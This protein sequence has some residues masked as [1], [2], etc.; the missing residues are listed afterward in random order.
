[1]YIRPQ[2]PE[3]LHNDK[4]PSKYI[5]LNKW[6]GFTVTL[7]KYNNKYISARTK[8]DLFIRSTS[9]IFGHLKNL[10]QDPSNSFTTDNISSLLSPLKHEDVQSLTLDIFG[11]KISKITEAD[12]D[13][14]FKLLYITLVN[15]KVIP[16]NLFLRPS[17]EIEDK[18]VTSETLFNDFGP[19]RFDQASLTEKIDKFIN[20][21]SKNNIH[22]KFFGKILFYLDENNIVIGK[23]Y[24]IAPIHIL[25]LQSHELSNETK[26]KLLDALHKVYEN[27]LPAT[28]NNIK[29]Y[30]DLNQLIFTKFTDKILNFISDRPNPLQEISKNKPSMIILMGLPGCGKSTFSKALEKVGWV[31]VNQDEMKKRIVCERITDSSFK[32]NKSVIVDRCNFDYEQRHHFIKIANKYGI[33]DIQCIWLDIPSE[34]CKKRVFDREGHPTIPKGESGMEIID[35]FKKNLIKPHKFEGFREIVILKSEE[36]V[37]NEIK[38]YAK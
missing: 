2:Y 29:N 34:I 1:M 16:Y 33:N 13:I 20:P 9:N 23:S 15:G 26:T 11:K 37:N 38:K 10:L 7:F 21:S 24:F 5:L 25:Q 22:S 4:Q 27:N 3:E 30:S 35:K 17:F 36:E 8:S 32:K 31:R 18:K 6:E 14:D 19:F 28:L 12:I